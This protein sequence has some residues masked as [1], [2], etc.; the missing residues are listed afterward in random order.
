MSG[1]YTAAQRQERDRRY[2]EHV[3]RISD[4]T[5]RASEETRLAAT[6]AVEESLEPDEEITYDRGDGTCP[7]PIEIMRDGIVPTK[8]RVPPKAR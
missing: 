7:S 5:L 4:P 2:A 1:R 8:V 3:A 6:R